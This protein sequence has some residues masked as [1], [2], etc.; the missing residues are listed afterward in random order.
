MRAPR[1]IARLERHRVYLVGKDVEIWESNL[2][3]MPVRFHDWSLESEPRPP[4][5]LNCLFSHR[6]DWRDVDSGDLATFQ[7]VRCVVTYASMST[8]ELLLKTKQRPL[9]SC[10]TLPNSDLSDADLEHIN[11]NV[12]FL[13]IVGVDISDKGL[14]QISRLSGLRRLE[15][16]SPYVTDAG[17]AR[18]LGCKELEVLYLGKSELLTDEVFKLVGEFPKLTTLE[19]DSPQITDHG[20]LMLK[21]HSTLEHIHLEAGENIS[22]DALAEVRSALDARNRAASPG[23]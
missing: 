4:G 18:L 6:T 22:S 11:P 8:R 2:N 21:G 19:I 9:L 23:D 14:A 16:D 10:L 5:D 13:D 7:A 3:P 17:V 15:I 12:A 20:L 1:A